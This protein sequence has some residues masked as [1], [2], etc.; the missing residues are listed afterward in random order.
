[1]TRIRCLRVAIATFS[2]AAVPTFLVSACNGSDRVPASDSLRVAPPP[3]AAAVERPMVTGAANPCP[4]TGLW[5]LCTLERRMRQS[6]FVARRAEREAP[7]RAGFS[8]KPVVYSLGRSRIEV[9][10]Y[11][12]EAGLARDMAALDTVLVV[13]RGSAASPWETTPTLIRS[14]NLAVVLLTS[15]PLQA[16]RLALAITAGA[17]QPGSPR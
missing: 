15:S 13:P 5:A 16:E 14:G 3:A 12:D 7:E 17:P 11:K 9:F 10:V 1:M 8:V 2:A 6:G 4:H